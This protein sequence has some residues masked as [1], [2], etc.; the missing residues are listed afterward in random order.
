MEIHCFSEL[1]MSDLCSGILRHAK[2]TILRLPSNV[3]D[4]LQSRSLPS[5]RLRLL[6]K[7]NGIRPLMNLSNAI[8]TL[9]TNGKKQFS[10]NQTMECVHRA[11]MFE[12]NRKKKILLGSSVSNLDD[13]Y[14]RLGPVLE[15]K[16]KCSYC[17]GCNKP[18][19][20]VSVDIER[21]FDT[22][23]P[24]KLFK[25]VRKL[26]MEDEYLI[27]K[28]WILKK[29]VRFFSETNSQYIFF[30]KER[31]AFSS[32]EL[33]RFDELITR[34]YEKTNKQNTVFVDGVIY[35][36]LK[37]SELLALLQEHLF[38]NIVSMNQDEFIQR[39]V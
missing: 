4:L 14:Q 12:V 5:S 27:R 2:H 25:I 35:D 26:L 33:E 23:R 31:P 38:C 18:M 9:H 29:N 16:Q 13:I 15:A 36:Y 11:L 34:V 28:H 8:K 7:L 6:P 17:N 30:K 37:K 22:I 19:Y 39:Q 1:A 10:T 24:L 3:A 32:G 20:F 21:C